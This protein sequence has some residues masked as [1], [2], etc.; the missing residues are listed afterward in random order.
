M[1]LGSY[2]HSVDAKGRVAVPASL[3]RGLPEGSVISIG[4]EGRLV[5]RPPHEWAALQA[6]YQLTSE[7][8]A[9]ER[10]YMRLLY[11]SAREVELDSQ[12]RLLLSD[13]HRSWAGISD[14]AVFLG[15]NN[16][17]ELVGESRWDQES[18]GVAPDTFTHLHDNLGRGPS[19]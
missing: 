2:R 14:R 9:D 10:R 19:A 17:V 11:A 5:I 13:E 18:A 1:F 6:R 7:T 16:V 12:G 15:L 3:R 8:P 4:E